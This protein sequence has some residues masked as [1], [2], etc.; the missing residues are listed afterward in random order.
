MPGGARWFGIA[1]LRNACPIRPFDRMLCRGDGGPKP[2][3]LLPLVAN[4]SLGEK[5]LSR[6][7]E[8]PI[9]GRKHSRQLSVWNWIWASQP[10]AFR[11]ASTSEII[12][13]FMRPIIS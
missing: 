13:L 6:R 8:P 5:G 3:P 11:N 1:G 4:G 9:F 10:L 7:R 2:T 12:R